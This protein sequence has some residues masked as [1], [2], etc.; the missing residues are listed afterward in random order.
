MPFAKAEIILKKDK[1][2]K[3]K[4]RYAFIFMSFLI[5]ALLFLYSGPERVF[6][7]LSL[8]DKG[9]LFYAFL[10]ATCAAILRVFKWKVL[11][12]NV[13][14]GAVMPVQFLGST[15]SNLTPGKFGEPVKSVLLKMKTGIPVSQSLP[16]IIWERICDIAALVLFAALF[17]PVQ[18]P[19]AYFGI[20]SVLIFSAVVFVFLI[21]LYRKSF[22]LWVF[23]LLKKLP[24][25]DKI[26][27]QFVESFY[28]T[29]IELKNLFASFFMTSL[30]WIADG[31]VF[32]RFSV[33]GNIG[34]RC[35]LSSRRAGVNR[36]CH[37]SHTFFGH[38][39]FLGICGRFYWKN[40]YVLVLFFSWVCLLCPS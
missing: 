1:T 15:V 35:K 7:M 30:A 34:R 4:K 26:S 39:S 5:L 24:F 37:G 20:V 18:F 31:L 8:S 32:C 17:F 28:Q 38:G 21:V 11:L 19:L 9:I 25:T 16:S 3:M 13:P 10:L 27:P 40:A 33:G 23:G 14:F 12:K 29:K 2:T 6:R 22:G 36:Q